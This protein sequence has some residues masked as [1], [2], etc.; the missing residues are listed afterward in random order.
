VQFDA[1]WV[2]TSKSSSTPKT[3]K[4]SS[5]NSCVRCYNV[6]IDALCAQSQHVNAEQVLVQSCDEAIG[7]E[8]DNLNLE[9]KRLEQKVIMLE[10]KAN[11]QPSQDNRRNM[12]NMFEKGRTT[13]KLAPQHQMKPT[14]HMKEERANID[15]KTEYA[16]SVFLIARRPHIKNGVS[17]KSGDKNNLRVNSNGKEFIKFTMGNSYQDKKQSLNN[18][19][20]VSH[21]NASYVSHMSY[22]N[23]DASYVLIRTNLVELLLYMLGLTTRG[24][25]LVCGCQNVLLLI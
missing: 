5:S 2:S 7:K 19:N 9:V 21:A 20:H 3:T 14:Y 6:D 17:Y 4:T 24:Q 15:E 1:L 18:T 11:A 12:M 22:H 8:N 16:R 10:K 23:F 25:R 13:P